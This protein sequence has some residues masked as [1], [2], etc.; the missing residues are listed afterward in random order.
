MPR[1]ERADACNHTHASEDCDDLQAHVHGHSA[2]DDQARDDDET[3]CGR[4]GHRRGLGQQHCCPACSEPHERRWQGPPRLH[5][6]QH[7]A[8]CQEKRNKRQRVAV[9]RKTLDRPSLQQSTVHPV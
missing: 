5:V 2:L 4:Q 6:A 9:S 3:T 1:K 7:Q 8:H